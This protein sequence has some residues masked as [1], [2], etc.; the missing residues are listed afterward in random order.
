MGWDGMGYASNTHEEQAINK[1]FGF[2]TS[3]M[4]TTWEK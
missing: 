4:E 2:K 1:H 3:K